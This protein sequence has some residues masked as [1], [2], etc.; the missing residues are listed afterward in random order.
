LI[1]GILAADAEALAAAESMIERKL[2]KC[3]LKSPEWAFIHSSYYKNETGENIIKKFVTVED[4]I[5]PDDIA[6]IKIKTNKMEQKLAKMLKSPLSRPVNL[7]PGY[8]EPSKLVLAT[9]KNFSH[10]IYIGKK[11]WAEVTLFYNKG[12]WQS[13][14]YTFPDHKDDR[15]HSFFSQVRERL[16]GQLELIKK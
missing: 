9:T 6:G 5:Y 8:I 13:F 7:D 4:L 16:K 3:D 1:V 14:S 2:G 15:Y 12:Q 10:R 11:I